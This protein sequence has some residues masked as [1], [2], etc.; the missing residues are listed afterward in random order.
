[1]YGNKM[2][3]FSTQLSKRFI[4]ITGPDATKFLQ[5]QTSCDLNELTVDNFSYSTLNTPKGRMYCLF[6]VLKTEHGFLLS[7]D[8]SLLE[9][10]LQKLSKYA[11]FFKCE[12]Q[13]DASFE[14]F[15]ITSDHEKNYHDFL[16]SIQLGKKAMS[17]CVKEGHAYFLN[18][19]SQNKLA[20]T[21]LKKDSSQ[22]QCLDQSKSMTL[23]HWFA[24]ETAAGIPELYISS[25]EEFVLQSLNLHHL[26]GV[27]FKKGCYTGQEIIAR[28]KFLGKQK[29][30]AYLLHSE[31]QL[32]QPPLAPVYDKD[33]A[34]RGTIIR[35]HWSEHTGS[36]A[37]CIL[38][39]EA[40]LGYEKVFFSKD[41]EI[42]FSVK[43]INYSEFE[44]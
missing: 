23:D 12:L 37:L 14:A 19:S 44:T 17:S 27:S 3:L 26:G 6:K 9:S 10:T 4:S 13:E 2:N 42:P 38:P 40:A 15:G 29:K 21:W 34:K 18:I 5:G 36:I 28:M 25:Q 33:G 43:E 32:I 31:H 1:M 24:L 8:E 22:P 41:L 7:M 20:E 16:A 39:I 30:Q 35:S 11:A